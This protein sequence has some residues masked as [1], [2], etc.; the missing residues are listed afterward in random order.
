MHDLKDS[1]SLNVCVLI[2]TTIF[3][4]VSHQDDPHLFISSESGDLFSL[5]KVLVQNVLE[6]VIFV[7]K[8]V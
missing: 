3:S 8:T 7:F 1:T 6:L 5:N 4:I 2:K